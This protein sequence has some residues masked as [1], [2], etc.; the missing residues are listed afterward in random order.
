MLEIFQG[1]S[2]LFHQKDDENEIKPNILKFKK[3]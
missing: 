1:K 3:F 2:I